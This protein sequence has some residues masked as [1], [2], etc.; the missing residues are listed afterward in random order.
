MATL[1]ILKGVTPGKIY[2][3][4]RNRMVIGR[5]ESCDIVLNVPAVS[6]EHAVIHTVQGKFYLEDLKSRNKTYVNNQEVN[7]KILLKDNDRIKI[8]DNLMAFQEGSKPPLPKGLLKGMNESDADIAEE[9]EDSSSTVEATISQ[10]S[11]HLLESQP[12]E[13]LAFLLNVVA[14]LTQTLNMDE[15][16][17]KVG[18][19]LFEVFRQ[20]DRVFIILSDEGKL[21]PKVVKTRGRSGDETG[22]RF[23]RTIINRCLTSGEALLSEDAS[24]GKGVDLSQS[25]ADCKIRS[26]MCAPIIGKNTQK[27]FGVIQLDT[28]D[29]F[30]KFKQDDLQLLLAVAGQAA[31][32]MENATMHQS[33]VARAGLERDLKTATDVQKS[34]LPKKSPQAAGYEFFAHYESAQEVGGDYYDFV[35]LPGGKWAIMVGDVAG[36]GV[37]AALL[38]AKV[39]SDARFTLLTE[40]NLAE[41]VYKLNDLMQEAGMLDRFVTFGACLLDPATHQVTCVSAGHMPPLMIRKA[42]GKMEEA[43]PRDLAG[44]PLGVAEGIPYD[45]ATVALD[46]GDS[47]L[48]YTD[49]VSEAKNKQEAEFQLEGIYSALKAGPLTPKVMGERLVTT[50]KKHFVGCKQHD[51]ITVVCF[52]RL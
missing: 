19:S 49:G 26:V 28:Q 51:D 18:N 3:L 13:R 52:G 25:I 46:P 36:K 29:R 16:L 14:D 1:N 32:A 4:D 11:K 12:S 23:S 17:P 9:K 41:T 39:S 37:P 2:P 40:P 27:A 15:L 43:T 22:A 8:C 44:L 30:K 47:L 31:V 38:M 5:Q 24:S 10:S 34:F 50:L 20:A 45:S 7:G 35:P 33:L 6:R 42:S 48:L 21:I